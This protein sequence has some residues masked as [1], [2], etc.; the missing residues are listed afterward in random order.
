MIAPLRNLPYAAGNA[1]R[2]VF[3]TLLL[4]PL[5]VVAADPAPLRLDAA[6][7]DRQR[8]SIEADLTANER[9]REISAEDRRSVLADL[10]LI[11]TALADGQPLG[12]LAAAEQ[13]SLADA[14]ARVN[15]ILARAAADSRMVCTRERPIGTRMAVNVCRTVAD[16]RRSREEA[17]GLSRGERPAEALDGG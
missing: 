7:L 12:G 3:S 1:M 15:A 4:L 13:A 6:D 5:L 9:Y 17:Q 2:L 14:Q 10:A 8:A 16:R 11:D